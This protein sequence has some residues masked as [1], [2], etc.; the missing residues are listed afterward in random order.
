MLHGL[1]L[2]HQNGDLAFALFVGDV[3]GGSSMVA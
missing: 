3:R 2:L 1:C